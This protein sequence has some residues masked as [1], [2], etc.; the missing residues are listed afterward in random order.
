MAEISI[1][2]LIVYSVICYT[3]VIGLIISAFRSPGSSKEKGTISVIWLIPSLLAS[4]MMASAGGIIS[5][6]TVVISNIGYNVTDQTIISNSTTTHT[7]YIQLVQPVW[8][9]LHYLLFVVL[10]IYIIWH[11]LNLLIKH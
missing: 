10:L 6:E 7:G 1:I 4:Y 9:T 11:M 5:T 2:E 3:G 8:V